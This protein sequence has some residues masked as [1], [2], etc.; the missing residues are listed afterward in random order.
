MITKHV[1]PVA[2]QIPVCGHDAVRIRQASAHV[3]AVRRGLD[4]RG[5]RLEK[6]LQPEQGLRELALKDT[7]SDVIRA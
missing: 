1:R 4:R 6:F 2:E 5:I 3:R 7:A